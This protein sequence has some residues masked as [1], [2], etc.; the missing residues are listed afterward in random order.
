MTSKSFLLQFNILNQ[1]EFDL[2]EFFM[3]F[4]ERGLT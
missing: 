1:L 2:P 3:F 4:Y